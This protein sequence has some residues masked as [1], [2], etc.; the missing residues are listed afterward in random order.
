MLF[1]IANAERVLKIQMTAQV[2]IVLA[3]ASGV[4]LMPSGVAG[5]TAEGADMK[6]RVINAA[7]DAESRTIKIGIKGEIM[8]EVTA[9]LK[10]GERVVVREITTAVRAA[11]SALSARPVR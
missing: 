7:G 8:T 1:D 3:Q 5:N 4:L 11:S 9:G 6:I 10:E 2:F